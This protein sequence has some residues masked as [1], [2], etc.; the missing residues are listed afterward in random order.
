MLSWT[1]AR[2]NRFQGNFDLLSCLV[3]GG[4]LV[5]HLVLQ[6]GHFAF[7]RLEVVVSMRVLDPGAD[8]FDAFLR[9][10]LARGHER[11][12]AHLV[13]F[14]GVPVDQGYLLLT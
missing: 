4:V 8:R 5:G 6:T 11:V 3:D 14:V 2:L 1:R 10:A 13:E 12:A 7:F 9:I